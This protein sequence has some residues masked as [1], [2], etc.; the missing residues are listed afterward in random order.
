MDLALIGFGYWGKILLPYI[1]A[2]SDWN[3]K[4]IYFPSLKKLTDKEIRKQFG[5]SFTPNLED[6]WRDDLRN[7]IIA[8]P[9]STHFNLALQALQN[10]KNV[11]IEK[12]LAKTY[13]E[14]LELKKWAKNQKKIIFTDY[15]YTFSQALKK[16][17]EL[18]EA[19]KIGALQYIYV[20]IKQLG[21]F[22]G[23]D[24]YPVLAS[25]GLSIINLFYPLNDLYFSLYDTVVQNNIATSGMLLCNN[26]G[27]KNAVKGM[28]DVSLNHPIKE[29][30]VVLYGDK[31]TLLYNPL[32]KDT[33]QLQL[34][35][36]EEGSQEALLLKQ[37]QYAFDE[38]NNLQWA[39]Q[40]YADVV[41]NHK[42]DNLILSTKISKIL[43]EL[44]PKKEYHGS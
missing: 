30:K 44:N 28:I 6:I 18:L 36:W 3:L 15:T 20:A 24:V 16:A 14:C 7:V 29:R 10:G 41:R 40:S 37:E 39:L 25:H 21:R 32:S 11:F 19:G 38:N 9:I 43:E 22:S 13:K 33:L 26:F 4:Y 23:E 35:S 8:T 1:D 12:P 2:S 5:E 27:K 17:K 34:Y 31:G 42:A